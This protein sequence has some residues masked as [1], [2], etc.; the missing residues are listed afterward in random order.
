M[1]DFRQALGVQIRVI[2]ALLY[3]EV[4]AQYGATKMGYLWAVILPMSQTFILAVIFWGI[5]RADIFGTDFGSITLFIATGFLSLNLFTGISNQVMNSNNANKALFGYPLVLPFDAMIARVILSTI[6]TLVSFATTLLLL[7][8]LDFWEPEIDSILRFM[9]VISVTALLGFGVGLINSYLVLYLPS[10]TN[11]YSI[12]TRP[13][14]FMSG[15]FYL[16]SDQLPPTVL[17][18][19]YY[20][21]ILHCTEWLRSAFYNEWESKFTDFN[22]LIPF[23]VITLFVGLLTQRLS[24]KKARE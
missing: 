8:Q 13:L 14:L 11:I 21:P 12:M 5:G 15:V 18:I 2:K 1:N 19:I 20:N 6:T 16:A 23:T 24:Q 9:A 22:Y 7:H 17:D 4:L 3:R 10:Y